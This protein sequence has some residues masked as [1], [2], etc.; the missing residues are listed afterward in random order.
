MKK[1]KERC[2]AI[3]YDGSRCVRD[4]VIGGYCLLH[5]GALPKREAKQ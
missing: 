3:I 4:G 5:W 1:K 2:K